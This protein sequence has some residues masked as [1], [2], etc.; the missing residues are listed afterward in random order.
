MERDPRKIKELEELVK[1]ISRE[2][3]DSKEEIKH[4]KNKERLEA[5]IR[6]LKAELKLAKLND[7]IDRLK[8]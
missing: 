2:I 3:E 8:Q 4:L 6:I 1:F 7:R 5:N